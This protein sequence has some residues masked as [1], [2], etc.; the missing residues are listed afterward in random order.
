MWKVAGVETY[1]VNIGD[2]ATS[3]SWADATKYTEIITDNSNLTIKVT[4]TGANT[5][6]Y[7]N[8]GNEWRFYQSDSGELTISNSNGNIISVTITYNIKNNGVLVYNGTNYASGEKIDVN[9]SSA[10]LSAGSTSGTS[11]QVKITSI[12]VEYSNN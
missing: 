10:V 3:N 4:K 9:D 6:K 2:Y 8:N 1:G 7:Y 11:G 12:I 5:G